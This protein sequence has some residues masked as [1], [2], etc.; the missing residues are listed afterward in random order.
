MK[1]I[2]LLVLNCTALLAAAQTSLNMILRGQWFDPT[3]PISSGLTYND[4]WGYSTP[5]DGREYAI[6]GSLT[7]VH[8]ID[9]TTPAAPVEVAAIAGGGSSL[10]RDMKTYS[11]YAYSVADQNPT[12]EGLMVFS[13]SD[14]P[15]SVTKVLQTTAFFSRCHN[16]FIEEATGR[17]YAAGCNTQSG[18][19]IVLDLVT[20]PANPTLLASVALPGGYVH[21]VFVRNNIAFCSHGFNGLYA[22]D[23]TNPGSPLTL[24]SLTG[25]PEAGYNHSSWMTGDGNRLVFCDE[26]HGSS[27]KIAD[28]QDL[29]DISVISLFK[30]ALLAPLHTNSIAHNPFIKGDSVYVSYYHEGV[31]VF[32]ISNPADVQRVA[33]YDTHLNHT[34]YG[35]YDGAWG[36]YPFLPSG[37]IIAS[38]T[39]TGLYVLS[40]PPAA[41]LPV[42]WGSFHADVEEHGIRLNWETITE[43]DNAGFEVERS[44]DGRPFQTIARIPA[45]G[46]SS[47]PQSY[48]AFD[49][50][51]APGLHYYRIRQTD[52]DGGYAFSVIV[53]VSFYGKENSI[54]LYP[55]MVSA[56]G[57]VS[58]SVGATYL[59]P[60]LISL[61][62]VAGALVYQTGVSLSQG[63]NTWRWPAQLGRSGIYFVRIETPAGPHAFRVLV[64]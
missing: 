51:P 6:I 1:R 5:D 21:D 25:Y 56:G 29:S 14:L 27:V 35:G 18:G 49:R 3:L 26:T 20:D 43:R 10:W 61:F 38:D 60:V 47:A 45:Q 48:A 9:I 36:L 44:T 34:N 7:K 33:Y 42:E 62:D 54:R 22:Y 63:E 15:N 39:K 52:Y 32:D 57:P 19:L 59:S 64:Q 58:I 11:K 40:F 41:P 16:I 24:G 31:Q 53:S 23:L 55:T 28:I 12:T 50:S 17:L 46:N 4:I 30:S 37:N 2:L 13:L 8:F